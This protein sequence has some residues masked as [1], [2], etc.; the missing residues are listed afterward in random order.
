MRQRHQERDLQTQVCTY[1]KRKYPDV[2][3]LS[4]PS[5]M[6]VS[7]YQARLLKAQ[8]SKHALPDLWIIHPSMHYHGLILELKHESKTPFKSDGTL[9]KDQHLARQ[10]ETLELLQ[11][12]KYWANFGVG[13]DDCIKQIDMYMSDRT[14]EEFFTILS[15]PV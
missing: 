13:Y 4:E 11:E 10:A 12:R 9:R 1:I 6:Y 14:L 8:R 3:F 5:G 15:T 2:V 7:I